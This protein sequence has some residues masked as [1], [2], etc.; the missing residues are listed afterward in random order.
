MDCRLVVLVA[1][2]TIQG[3]S[4]TPRTLRCG[5]RRVAEKEKKKKKKPRIGRG[6][7]K[8]AADHR[9]V[10]SVVFDGE[11]AISADIAGTLCD[12]AERYQLHHDGGTIAPLFRVLPESRGGNGGT[13]SIIAAVMGRGPRGSPKVGGR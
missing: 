10:L 7:E 4:G 11:G 9:T 2:A 13:E 12:L 6:K 1:G 3:F 5:R 8:K